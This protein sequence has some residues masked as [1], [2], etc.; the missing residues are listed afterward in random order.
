MPLKPALDHSRPTK[1]PTSKFPQNHSESVVPALQAR[2]VYGLENLAFLVGASIAI[3]GV[4]IHWIA[5]FLAPD[6]YAFLQCPKFVVESARNKTWVAPTGMVIIGFL[7]LACAVYALSGAGKMR[8]LP[9]TRT[10]LVTISLI[11]LV[12]GLILV[13]VVIFIPGTFFAFNV[14]G[15]LVWFVAG[16][17]FAVGTY[18]SWPRLARRG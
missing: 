16:L 15:S 1:F 12:R 18:Q 13:P 17:G 10:A 3:F 11:C 8:R 14:V 7:M 9:L 4:A 5:P 2:N 6:W